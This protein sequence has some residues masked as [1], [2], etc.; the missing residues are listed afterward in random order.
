MKKLLVVLAMLVAINANAQWV[1]MNG[2]DRGFVY[3]FASS[4]TNI[5]AGTYGGGV[6]RSTNNGEKWF[7][8]NNGL[9][10]PGCIFS[11]VY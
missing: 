8:I 2:P 9:T 4:G 6:F 11:F 10:N 1:Q 7:A 5:F 3:S